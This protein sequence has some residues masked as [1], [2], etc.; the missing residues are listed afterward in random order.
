MEWLMLLM[1]ALAAARATHLVADDAVPF[2][3]IRN[4]LASVG[5]HLDPNTDPSRWH[6]FAWWLETGMS[7]TFCVSIHA[8]FWAAVLAWNQGWITPTW[9]VF[10]V[11]W[12]A[13]AWVITFVESVAFT[14]NG[15]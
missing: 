8:G 4:R 15:D 12:F 3:W 2:G 6:R 10:A 1:L 11:T 7:C 9:A 13:V 5:S 14:L